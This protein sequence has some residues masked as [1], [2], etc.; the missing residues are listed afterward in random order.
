MAAYKVTPKVTLQF[1]IYNLTDNY[2]YESAYTNWAVPAPSRTFAMTLRGTLAPGYM[3]T[4]ALRCGLDAAQRSRGSLSH[5][6][7]GWVRGPSL[8][9][10]TAH[11]SPRRGAHRARRQIMAN[12]ECAHATEDW[13]P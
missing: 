4:Q 1:N 10:P 7:R 3:L 12:G 9:R 6:G 2:Y 13:R 8:S 11:P 5:V